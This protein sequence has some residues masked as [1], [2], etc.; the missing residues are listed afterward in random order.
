MVTQKR[1][2]YFREELTVVENARSQPTNK[3]TAIFQKKKISLSWFI[4]TGIFVPTEK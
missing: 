1:A 3:R 2:V 4:Q